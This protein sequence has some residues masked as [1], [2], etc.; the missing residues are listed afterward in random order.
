MATRLSYGFA[1]ALKLFAWELAQQSQLATE[2]FLSSDYG[3]LNSELSLCQV[4]LSMLILLFRFHHEIKLQDHFATM[5]VVCCF[6]K[7]SKLKELKL[8]QWKSTNSRGLPGGQTSY[9]DCP[10]VAICGCATIN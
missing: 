3:H 1:R 7:G 8:R 5:E 9:R 10:L 4:C 6:V 2:P